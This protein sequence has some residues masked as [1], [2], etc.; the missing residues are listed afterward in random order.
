VDNRLSNKWLERPGSDARVDVSASIAGRS[1]T[2]RSA[3]TMA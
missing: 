2:M 1:A 3:A